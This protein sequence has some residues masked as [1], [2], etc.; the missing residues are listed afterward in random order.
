[1]IGFDVRLLG[2]GTDTVVNARELEGT[3]LEYRDFDGAPCRVIDCDS[4]GCINVFKCFPAKVVVMNFKLA[5]IKRQ[6][7][8][9]RER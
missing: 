8:D 6:A 4:R 3:F 5:S 9:G 7:S 2:I 1:L